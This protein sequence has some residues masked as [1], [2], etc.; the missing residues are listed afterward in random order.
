MQFSPGPRS[1]RTQENRA[2][3]V[4]DKKRV[5]EK[6]LEHWRE[7]PNLRLGQLLECVAKIELDNRDLFYIE[8]GPLIEGLAR[9]VE[10]FG[11]ADR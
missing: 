5:C 8:D 11:K 7:M 6:L 9:F 2:Y 10:Q 4:Q 1:D 3:T